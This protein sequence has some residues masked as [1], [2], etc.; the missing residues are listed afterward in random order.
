[1]IRRALM[2][3]KAGEKIWMRIIIMMISRALMIRQMGKR[4]YG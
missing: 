4:L 1:M 2:I 3:R